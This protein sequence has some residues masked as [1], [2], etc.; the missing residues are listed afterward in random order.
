MFIISLEKCASVTVS[1][2]NE[3]CNTMQ[4]LSM[5]SLTM[6]KACLSLCINAW[7]NVWKIDFPLV[8]II[9]SKMG[10]VSNFQDL[11]FNVLLD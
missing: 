6:R 10:R 9:V 4:K 5:I 8:K 11:T 7:L 1:V 2:Q 3:N